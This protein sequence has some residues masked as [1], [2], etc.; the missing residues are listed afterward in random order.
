MRKA[1][2]TAL[3]MLAAISSVAAF[4]WVATR[5]DV[6]TVA[7]GQ[8]AADL[9]ARATEG[10]VIRLAP[11]VHDPFE[12]AMPVTVE[13]APGAVVRGPIT[14]LADGV[15]L[16]GLRIEGGE[17]GIVVHDADDVEIEGVTVAG[18]RLHGIEIAPG[19]ATVRGCAITG[20]VSPYAQALEVRMSSGRGH[21]LVEGCRVDSGQEG[22]VSHVSRVEFR[23]NLV[24]GTTLRA[25]V[26]TEMSEG[27]VADNRVEEVVGSAIY[28]GD[29]S[30]CEI[31]D[32]RVHGVAASPQNVPALDGWGVVGFYH[33]KL[34][35]QGNAVAE[36]AGGDVRL[37]MDTRL[38]DSFPLML[39][40]R[41][42]AGVWPGLAISVAIAAV[43]LA[44]V[45]A[46]VAP[47]ARRLRP[48]DGNGRHEA[49]VGLVAAALAV[50]AF[51]MVEHV[52]QV[53]QVYGAAAE[54]RSGLLGRALDVEWVHFA[55]NLA[56]LA[57]AWW[58][59]IGVGRGSWGET[60]RRAG[61]ILLAG[62]VIQTYHMVEHGAKVAQ[63]VA[64]GVAPTPGLLGGRVGLV[65][66]HFAINLAVFAAI[67]GGAI[68]LLR[69]G[70][71]AEVA[72]PRRR[73]R[74]S[75]TGA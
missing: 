10:S 40:P 18:A 59:A 73:L 9:I 35:L 55:Y 45:R 71:R 42:L 37:T 11:G 7:P 19:S 17:S 72:V 23:E 26:V 6:V 16:D 63:F 66:F 64:S 3:G 25:L 32:N 34:R 58:L 21:T 70:R 69:H 5:P 4:A 8:P 44:A 27:V 36:A 14:V 56:V 39:W 47:M 46:G 43:G 31:R 74:L 24:T 53:W 13:A 20:L 41:G 48:T 15:R 12:V 51:H 50:Q 2:V 67:A 52:V 75:P 61:P 22:L 62:A 33:S 49:L 54:H 65:W 29:M 38:V 57:F 30:H 28:C 1:G 60:A 68:P